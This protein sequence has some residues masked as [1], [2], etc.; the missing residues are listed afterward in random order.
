MARLKMTGLNRTG[1][2]LMVRGIL[3][4]PSNVNWVC[5][6]SDTEGN[7]VFSARGSD[8]VTRY[9]PIQD[10]WVGCNITTATALTAVYIYS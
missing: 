9:Y 3:I 4:D 5:A 1:D 6:I 7:V 8:A 10:T 2:T